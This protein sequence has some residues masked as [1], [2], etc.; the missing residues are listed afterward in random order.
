MLCTCES[1]LELQVMNFIVIMNE[2]GVL[3]FFP[4]FKAGRSVSRGKKFF[5]KKKLGA[6][7]KRAPP[8]KKTSFP[9]FALEPNP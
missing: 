9:L 7:A 8:P 1:C 6:G 3:S 4:K 5:S 2:L